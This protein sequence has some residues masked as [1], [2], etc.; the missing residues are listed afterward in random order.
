[1][2]DG[3]LDQLFRN[4]TA[5]V[6]RPDCHKEEAENTIDARILI[7]KLKIRKKI[8]VFTITNTLSQN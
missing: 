5:P 8:K 1:M 7:E 2:L 4:R 6:L 3:D